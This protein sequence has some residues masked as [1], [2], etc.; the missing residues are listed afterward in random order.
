MMRYGYPGTGRIIQ[1]EYRFSKEKEVSAEVNNNNG[2]AAM[3][4]L[5]AEDDEILGD[6][7]SSILKQ[8]GM[9]IDWVKDG[10]SAIG[11]LTRNL[12]DLVL[13]DLNLPKV[14]GLKVLST[15]RS[16]GKRTPVL[17][18]T[19]RTDL[20]D[21]ISALDGGADD[22]VMKP[23]EIDELCARIRALHRRNTG[24]AVSVISQGGVLLDPA[25]R[26]V[27]VDGHPVLL[28]KR[29]FSVLQ[30]LMENCGRVLTRS[31][32]EDALYGWG[33]EVESNT[34][35]VYIHNLRKKLGVNPIRTVRGVGYLF[36]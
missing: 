20:G 5:L 26:N 21:K 11:C 16:N 24:Q 29:E 28:S 31:R 15:L 18:L 4:L 27:S 32:I 23:F 17:V 34:V 3:R 36:E 10:E 33:G 30:L 9:T 25:T 19:A 13:L 7:L 2:V 35:E 1:I 8:R 6:G 12:Y 14:S 22:Y